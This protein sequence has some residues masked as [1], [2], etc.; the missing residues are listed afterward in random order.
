MVPLLTNAANLLTPGSTA[1][2]WF[3][4]DLRVHDHPA[5]NAALAFR[6]VVCLYVLDDRLLNGQT[7]SSNRTWFLRE[8]LAELSAAIASR[9]A[10]SRSAMEGRSQL[11]PPSLGESA[12][13]LCSLAATTAHSDVRATGG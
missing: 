12:L 9:G 11:S 2:V 6:R 4:R 8:S 10:A 13:K 3:R 1:L 7:A 5:L